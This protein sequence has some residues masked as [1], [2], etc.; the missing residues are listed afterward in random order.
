MLGAVLAFSTCL[1]ALKPTTTANQ[2]AKRMTKS[3]LRI[4]AVG[5]QSSGVT[6]HRLA[7]P[8]SIME[9]EYCLI[10]DTITEELLKEKNFNV[11]VVNRFLE[12][13]PLM[14]LLTWRKRF[15]FK[16]VVD[17]DDFW[18]LFD[19]HLS[20]GTYRKLGVTRI[21]KDYIKYADVVTTTHYRLYLEI[22]R[23]NKNC[24]IL[25]NA[26]PFDKD[27]FTAVKIETERVNI[28]HTGS[29]THYPDIQQLATPIAQLAK[30]KAFV[31]STRMLLCGWN[32]FNKWHWD[33]MGKI[34]TANEKLDYKI[35]ESLPV[36]LYMNFYA[37]ADMLIVPLLDN[38]FNRLK[39]NL[40]ALEAGAKRIPILAYNRAPYDDIPTIFKV[41]NW[42]RDIRRMAFSKQMRDDYGQANGDYVREHYDIFKINEERFATYSKLIAQ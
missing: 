9:K 3:Q 11:V 23:L 1:N 15:G 7:L 34:Y 8:L 18:E 26:L 10:T 25:P 38:K 17:I 37:E 36:N 5:S 14:T 21:I 41:E 35:L 31:D 12:H 24:V 16:L 32:N 27:Q 39:S 13:L 33:R 19:K 29:I 42:E 28:T 30:S 40:K 2:P 6:Y 22:I 20:A 4:L